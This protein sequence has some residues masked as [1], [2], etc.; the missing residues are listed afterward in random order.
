MSSR[1]P[2]HSILN[3]RLLPIPFLVASVFLVAHSVNA[4]SS[5]PPLE[6]GKKVA[7]IG[8]VM[9]ATGHERA[10]LEN[11]SDKK[12]AMYQMSQYIRDVG[13]LVAIEKN[14]VLFRQG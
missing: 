3:A 6:V 13:E 2:D 1:G 7:L 9:G 10:I 8:I 5:G 14:R 11:L 4:D 12:Q